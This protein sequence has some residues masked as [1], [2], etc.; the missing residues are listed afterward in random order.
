MTNEMLNKA[1]H[2]KLVNEF[3][4]YQAYL[5]SLPPDEI[6]KHTY[7]HTV[8]QDI[9][10]IM[11]DAEFEP[12]YVRA[13]LR[14]RTPLNDIYEEYTF[15]ETEHMDVLRD[16][17]EAEAKGVIQRERARKRSRAELDH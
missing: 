17:F 9:V 1:L 5:T 14:S 13:L 16:C 6:L 4:Q 10:C 2:R 8:K 3:R 11:E 12:K 15:R 7:E